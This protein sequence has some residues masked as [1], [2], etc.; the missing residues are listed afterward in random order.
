MG[1]RVTGVRPGAVSFG[2]AA[3][4][5]GARVWSVGGVSSGA[6]T[7]VEDVW[8]LLCGAGEEVFDGEAREEEL[9]IWSLKATSSFL[10]AS[11]TALQQQINNHKIT[12]CAAAVK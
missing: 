2:G 6:A 8:S 1:V 3:R 11:T 12:P 5:T 4:V 10:R 7:D 9:M